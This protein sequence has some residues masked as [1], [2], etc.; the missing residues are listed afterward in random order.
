MYNDLDI[1]VCNCNFESTL[2]I[3][4]RRL[5]EYG[6]VVEKQLVKYFAAPT[7]DANVDT[8]MADGD[9]GTKRLVDFTLAD[10]PVIISLVNTS[11]SDGIVDVLNTFDLSVCAIR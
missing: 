11:H 9:T 1:F 8:V 4:E 6:Y 5:A 3:F 2:S 10:I 7:G